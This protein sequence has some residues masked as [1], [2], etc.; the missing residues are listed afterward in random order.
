MNSLVPKLKRLSV[1]VLHKPTKSAEKDQHSQLTA[2]SSSFS[3]DRVVVDTDVNVI[4]PAIDEINE[5]DHEESES[6]FHELDLSQFTLVGDGIK[7]S[8][9]DNDNGTFSG[10]D[11]ASIETMYKQDNVLGLV[12]TLTLLVNQRH[13]GG[14]VNDGILA[15]DELQHKGDV[16]SGLLSSFTLQPWYERILGY[17]PLP[18]GIARKF[19]VYI[20]DRKTFEKRYEAMPLYVRIGLNLLYVGHLKE[21]LLETGILDK[22]LEHETIRQG[23]YF[24]SPKSVTQIASFIKTYNIPT[25]ELLTPDIA[26]FNTFNEFFYRK[27][28]PNARPIASPSD[29]YKVVSTSDSR[30]IVFPKVNEATRFWVKGSNFSL[31]NL[32]QDDVLA[33]QFEGAPM[34]IFRL[35][36]Q[37]YHRFHAPITAKCTGC[38]EI[39]GKYYTVN[40]LAVNT[41]VNVL[42]ENARVV[43]TFST[44]SDE[45]VVN[46]LKQT[47]DFV[48][49]PIGA[50]LVGSIGLTGAQ[51]EVET[52]KGDEL[53]YFAFGGS[54]VVVI[55]PPNANM[56]FDADLLNNSAK[57]LETLVKMGESIG[58]FKQDP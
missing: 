7:A 11:I 36:P 3:S 42:T 53:G 30:L 14:I 57:G 38:R 9:I 41:S 4:P 40:P 43:L 15:N 50:M 27:L 19:G 48:L 37:D 39:P 25:D 26:S 33:K 52:K 55:F 2:S 29:E 47:Y 54:T 51:P 44:V 17:L 18:S 23:R 32:L 34:A 35:A 13:E 46:K 12:Q 31:A 1:K 49:I 24:D 21:K 8:D 58:T 56:Q 6:D 16:E 28:K 20:I 22:I 45:S 10:V 5:H